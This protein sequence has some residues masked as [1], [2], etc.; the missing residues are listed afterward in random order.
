M[1]KNE[2]RITIRPRMASSIKV[3][4]DG[5]DVAPIGNHVPTGDNGWES[6]SLV[7]SCRIP[8]RAWKIE[9]EKDG[10]NDPVPVA[11]FS[12]DFANYPLTMVRRTEGKDVVFDGS[13]SLPRSSLMDDGECE[14][15]AWLVNSKKEIV[16]DAEK[17]TVGVAEKDPF[18]GG[19]FPFKV[20]LIS[21]S[22]DVQFNLQKDSAY[23]FRMTDE[24]K[25]FMFVNS[26]L[27]A[28]DVLMSKI[29]M[30][31]VGPKERDMLLVTAARGCIPQFLLSIIPRAA[32]L[33]DTTIDKSQMSCL[34]AFVKFCKSVPEWAH[35]DGDAVLEELKKKQ[36]EGS[37]F[38][39]VNAFVETHFKK[40]EKKTFVSV[41]GELS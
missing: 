19:G 12:S 13:M 25:A 24:N 2:C 40:F 15:R 10:G 39:Q 31:K 18:G 29:I 14:L 36:E 4:L 37:L 1:R 34:Q 32:T 23:A 7:F 6:A 27:R 8:Q 17:W 21:F 26:D 30:D 5:T 35:L 28:G 20:K 9:T 33:K 41:F 16:A 3:T 11:T 38:N 22:E